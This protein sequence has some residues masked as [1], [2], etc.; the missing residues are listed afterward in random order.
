M[1]V[2]QNA[3]Q[4][5]REVKDVIQFRLH[6]IEDLDIKDFLE[7]SE[8]DITKTIKKVIREKILAEKLGVQIAASLQHN[9][10]AIPQQI[11]EEGERVVENKF[12]KNQ[13]FE[14]DDD[15]GDPV[16]RDFF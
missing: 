13:E 4:K 9:V 16:D 15:T 7:Q 5:R 8:S 6:P 3:N 12:I 11:Q 2:D 1:K 10:A 14:K